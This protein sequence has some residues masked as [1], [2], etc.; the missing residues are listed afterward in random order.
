M[1]WMLSS[2]HWGEWDGGLSV[3]RAC[4]PTRS[5]TV[6]HLHVDMIELLSEIWVY[7]SINDLNTFRQQYIS[8]SS[9]KKLGTHVF[10]GQLGSFNG[11]VLSLNILLDLFFVS[12]IWLHN[13]GWNQKGRAW[14]QRAVPR[15]VSIRWSQWDQWC[16]SHRA[17]ILTHTR[18][19]THTHTH[20]HK[21]GRAPWRERV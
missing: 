18:T 8:S 9:L 19:H 10:E 3:W 4:G 12:L 6:L 5:E 1:I 17:L 20:T 14:A 11:R 15:I 13:L 2:V 16:M 7:L 21:I